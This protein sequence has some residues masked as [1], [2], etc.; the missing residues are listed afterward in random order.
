MP[1]SARFRAVLHIF[2]P[3][4]GRED[5]RIHFLYRPIQHA[6]SHEQICQ[7]DEHSLLAAIVRHPPQP[8]LMKAE[9]LFAEPEGVLSLGT[10]VSIGCLNQN[11]QSAVRCLRQ[12]ATIA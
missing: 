11:E 2:W 5:T 7:C 12:H 4:S 9:P 1:I 8:R 3:K 6:T 10:G